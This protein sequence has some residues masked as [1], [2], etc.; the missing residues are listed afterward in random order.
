M[1]RAQRRALNKILKQSA[2]TLGLQV[3]AEIK[4][5]PVRSP[6]ETVRK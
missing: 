5:E 6:N 2:P 1:N 3:K 4:I